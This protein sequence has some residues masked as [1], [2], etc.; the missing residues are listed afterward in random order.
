MPRRTD[1]SR[2]AKTGV[3]PRRRSPSKPA[4]VKP[5]KPYP[6]FP[7]FPH[8]TRRWAKK[9][10]GRFVFFGPWED[11]H[12]ALER[13]LDQRDALLAGLVPR[14]G[15]NPR[16]TGPTTDHRGAV[17]TGSARNPALTAGS[18]GADVASSGV[19]RFGALQAG[20][21]AD[22]L[23]LRDL[24]NRYLTAKQ[25][26]LEAGELGRRSFAD[27][28]TAMARLIKL[29]RPHRLVSDFLP[30]DFGRLRGELAK[31]RGPLALSADITKVKGLFKFGYEE[32]L[33]DRLPRY[34][35]G[36]AKPPKRSVRMARAGRGTRMFEPEEISKLLANAGVQMRAM[37]LLGLNGGMGNTDVAA[38]PLGAV[39]LKRGVINFPR[40]KT[41][42]TRRAVLWPETVQALKAVL[43]VRP[44]AKRPEDERL[45]FITKYGLPWVR[46]QAPQGRG[47]AE[48]LAVVVDSVGL[49]FGKLMR[50]TKTY[51]S[52][53]AFY[54]LRHTFRTVADEVGDRRPIDLIMG[55][56]N[57]QDVATRYIERISDE[58]LMK[59]S[60]HVRRWVLGTSRRSKQLSRFRP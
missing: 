37:I 40:P 49:E 59:V 22:G 28:H 25:R 29:F 38:L 11:P 15:R 30:E 31:T 36:F 17:A 20:P 35:P 16:A 2:A 56:E 9:I 45:M 51:Q 6:E 41:G 3:S 58:R 19:S 14:P 52:G 42:I 33:L 57:G 48:R 60:D 4:R 8:A 26:R 46:V 53:R 43:Q 34:G 32:G 44:K 7:L 21:A 24:I 47:K 13:Y 50:G 5:A 23:T 55:H 54:G 12:G 27:Y 1:F 18:N 10:R 39:D